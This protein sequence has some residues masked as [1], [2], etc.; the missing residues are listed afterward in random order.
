MCGLAGYW[1]TGGLESDAGTRLN[2]M[3]QA[4][5]HR[6][7]DDCGAWFDEAAGIALGHRRL[8]IIDLSPAGHQPMTSASGRYIVSYNGEIY[9][10]GALRRELETSGAAPNWR[11]HSDTEVLLAAVDRWGIADTLARLNGMFAFA[12]WD[13]SR[14]VLTLARDRMGEK[15]LYYGRMGAT[16]LF[17]SEL[18]A[19]TAHPSFVGEIDRES[20]TS[21][22]RFNY[23]PAPLSIWQG[24][25]KLPPSSY[26]EVSDNGC[27]IGDP[28]RYWDFRSVAEKGAATPLPDG[29][30]LVDTVEALLRDAVR[31]RMEAD[32][33]LGAFLSGGVDSSTIVALMQQE[34]SQ[35]VRTFAIGLDDPQF[36]EAEHAKAVARHLG[37]DHTEIYVGSADALA[38][39]P[40]LPRIWDEPFADS[41]QIPT[42]L[43]SELTQQYVTVS[44]SGDGGDE[45]FGGYNRY[46]T[47]MRLWDVGSRLPAPARKAMAQVL[48]MRATAGAASALMR[49]APTRY[50]QLGFADRLPK[51]GRVLAQPSRDAAYR[52]FVSQ[53]DDPAEMVIG[54]REANRRDQDPE[55]ADFRQKMMYLDTLTYLPDDI[56]AKVDRAT[57][58]VSLEGRIPFLDH[59]VVELAWRLPMEVKIHRGT[60]K[61]ILRDILYRY[62]PS[63][64]IERPKMGFA[65]P[66][67]SWL[68]GPL[69]DWAET[70]L[71]AKRLDSEGYLRSGSVRALWD[72]QRAGRVNAS[73]ELWAL[74]MFQSWLEG[75]DTAVGH[76]LTEPAAA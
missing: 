32:V 38:A 34:S 68:A 65:V 67:G 24:I 49:I 51:A 3:T 16:L 43:V 2:A 17:S 46:I 21:F 8:S 27:N 4:I 69:R 50:R 9:N 39:V 41:S 76:G 62:V 37:T 36:N 52:R 15:P 47:G 59:R 14:R 63:S 28:V 53:N 73:A 31:L 56:L 19:L 42:L 48:Q 55:F 60:G 25:S 5:Q 10:H 71:D 12:L 64:L 70:L 66:I 13:R 57:M 23:I 6:G 26:I 11:G 72:D 45:L 58:A 54:G 44:L 74:L 18:K 22:M 33:P 30:E 75:Q 1:R 61:R 35:P 40:R 7:P 29:P 20:L